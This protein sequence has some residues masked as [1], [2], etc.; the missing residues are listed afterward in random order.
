MPFLLPPLRPNSRRRGEAAP[1]GEGGPAAGGEGEDEGGAG[2][3]AARDTPVRVASR[4]RSRGAR[5]GRADRRPHG[6]STEMTEMAKKE[7]KF[8]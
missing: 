5:Q 2:A 8:S 4:A 6:G 7:C 3:S 1:G